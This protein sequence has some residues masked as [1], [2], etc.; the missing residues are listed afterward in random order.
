MTKLQA[1]ENACVGWQGSHSCAP[2]PI[3]STAG[4]PKAWNGVA[5]QADVLIRS[6]P[7]SAV[8]ELQKH[9]TMVRVDVAY[10]QMRHA[11]VVMLLEMEKGT[12]ASYI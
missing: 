2:I 3:A 10:N 11:F 4:A 7:F 6:S 5:L 9:F 8:Y 12:I 1:A